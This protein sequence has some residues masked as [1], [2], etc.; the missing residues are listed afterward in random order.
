MVIYYSKKKMDK[1][2]SFKL[3]SLPR[4]NSSQV[5]A[6]KPQA[7]A[8]DGGFFQGFNKFA[9]DD[10]NLPFTMKSLPHPNKNK[11]SDLLPQKA[12]HLPVIEE[13]NVEPMAQLYSN[14]YNEAEKI[15]RWKLSVETEMKQKEKKIQENKKTIDAQRKAIQELQADPKKMQ[16]F[17]AFKEE[18]NCSNQNNP[19]G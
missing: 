2:K 12:K 7:V 9:D 14:L 1:E 8:G 19:V 16:S 15:K 10:F 18:E 13:E 4:L 17:I 3:F 11:S 6:V 5:S